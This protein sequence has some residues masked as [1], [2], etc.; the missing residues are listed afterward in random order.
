MRF[1]SPIPVSHLAE[2]F[3]A[4]LLGDEQQFAHGINEIHKV[5]HGDITFV[6]V[7]KYYRASLESAATIILI[8]KEV[9]CPP[10]KTLLVVDNPFDMYNSLVKEYR[11]FRPLTQMI[12]DSA[13][14]DPTS[15]IEP[16]VM[17]GHE[18]R[19]GKHCH[20]QGNTYI[21]NHTTIGDRVTV[22]AG[23]V[24][25]TDAFYYKTKE[26]HHEKWCS[27]GDVI[28]EDDVWI[29][30]ACTINKGVS[31]STIIGRGTKLDS[32]VHVG[33]GA[34]IGEHCLLAGQVAVGG[35]VRLGKFVKVYGQAGIAD[36]L[37]VGD[38]AIIYAQAGVLKDLEGGKAY[39]GI[40]AEDARLRFR[41]L[42]A[43]RSLLKK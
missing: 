5:E 4:K 41:E 9:E 19:I 24:I 23:S 3:N 27:G 16:N 12:S 35:K 26:D 10:G 7:E 21:G 15:V 13:T 42:V 31:G 36:S 29:G 30:A 2:R 39:F 37:T 6:D 20:I 34:V 28:I 43:I 25:G 22:E 32:Q 33:H 38:R 17:I 11:P 40:P 8:N 18:V 14:I 1:P